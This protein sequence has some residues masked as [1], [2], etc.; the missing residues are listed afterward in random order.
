MPDWFGPA[1]GQQGVNRFDV[2]L[3]LQPSQVGTCYLADSL[4]GVLLERVMRGMDLP[5]LS[6][7]RLRRLHVLTRATVTRD[8]V[9]IDLCAALSTVHRLELAD[10][11]APPPYDKTQGLAAA[12]SVQPH[13]VPVDGIV[14]CSRFGSRFTSVALWDTARS[15]LTWGTAVSLAQDLAA[16]ARACNRLGV[17]LVD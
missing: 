17:G 9:L 14:Y 6:V 1:V 10:V 16:L 12:W 3:R 7:D 2:P 5:I 11:V 13:P 15:A 8:L 4:E